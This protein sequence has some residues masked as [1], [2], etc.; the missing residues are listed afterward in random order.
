MDQDNNYP[1]LG[2]GLPPIG[3]LVPYSTVNARN[4]AS[5]SILLSSAIEGHVLVSNALPLKPPA[6]L[7]IFGYDAK[8][9]DLYDPGFNL[10]WFLGLSSINASEMGERMNASLG[11][12]APS[13]RSPAIARAGTLYTGGGS[14]SNTPAYISSLFEVLSQQAYADNTMLYW[15]FVD[16]PFDS[17]A[18]GQQALSTLIGEEI[19]FTGPN[20]YQDSDACL[21]FIN[22]FATESLDRPGFRDD[23]SDGLVINIASQCNNTIVVIH[24]AG[25]HLVDQW[26]DNPNITAIIFAYL[27]GQD[28]GRAL[29]EVLYDKASPSRKLP[30]SVPKNESAYGNT[31]EPSMPKGQFVKYPQSNFT[32]GLYVDYRAFN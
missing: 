6:A 14:G 18:L 1:A 15:D 31:L 4:P 19:P 25:V 2:V 32:E 21:V 27:S 9:T 7:S 28:L 20:V 16:D 29:V 13:V 11:I 10:V 8:G 3:S 26:A 12:T 23:Y 22:A 17:A 30:Y 24:N 5:K